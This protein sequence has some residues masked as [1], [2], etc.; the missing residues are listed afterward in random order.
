[1]KILVLTLRIPYPLDD[2]GAIAMYRALENLSRAG[3]E[4]TLAALNTR[5]HREDPG[6]MNGVVSRVVA[7]DVDTT[8]NPLKALYSLLFSQL[9]YNVS[10]FYSGK[11]EAELTELLEQEDFDVV[12]MEGIYLAMYLPVVRRLA[13]APALLRAHNVEYKIWRSY[14]QAETSPLKRWYFRQLAKK[15]E[16]FERRKLKKFHGVIA[17]TEEDGVDFR[18]LGYEGPLEAIPVGINCP[19]ST[20][21]PEENLALA[22]LG[23]LEWLPNIQGLRWFLEKVW[24]DV[25]KAVPECVFH[26][27]GKNP[28]ESLAKWKYPNTVIHGPVPD[29]GVYLAKYPVVVV[30]LL[31]GSGVRVKILE[32]F[33]HRRCVVTTPR[34][35]SGIRAENGVHLAVADKPADFAAECVRLLNNPEERKNL[36]CAARSLVEEAYSWRALTERMTEFYARLL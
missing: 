11:F 29:A 26:I 13:D 32:A 27:A 7:A 20:P 8:P 9:P 14:A 33:A 5:K 3:H 4:V 19:E 23:S 25:L 22:F 12:Q 34:G 21:P 30:P 24:P 28:P 15:G 35:I 6:V 10:R 31:S 18:K 17:L 2:G 36:A 1:M 16:R